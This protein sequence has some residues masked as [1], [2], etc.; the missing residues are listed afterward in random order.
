[1]NVLFHLLRELFRIDERSE[2][3]NFCVSAGRWLVLSRSKALKLFYCI[4]VL[5]INFKALEWF[6]LLLKRLLSWL[7]LPSPEHGFRPFTVVPL[8]HPRVYRKFLQNLQ[9]KLNSRIKI[10]KPRPHF[11]FAW[12]KA[13]SNP[14]TKVNYP[15]VKNENH[16]SYLKMRIARA[17]SKVEVEDK[18]EFTIVNM[19]FPQVTLNLLGV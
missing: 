2:S 11:L 1:M 19:T 18:R 16:L 17:N 13:K 7:R 10:L 3:L 9:G 12:P 8:F 14:K 6:L 4:L 5:K 15:R